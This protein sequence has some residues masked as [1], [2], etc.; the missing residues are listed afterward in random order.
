MT[1]YSLSYGYL[2]TDDI[3]VTVN[4]TS[5]SFSFLTGAMVRL[6][7]APT[8]TVVITRHTDIDAAKVVFKDGSTQTAKQRNTQTTQ[9][10]YAVQEAVDKSENSLIG[11]GVEVDAKGQRLKNL[12][13]PID[14][15][16]AVTRAAMEAYSSD[17]VAAGTAAQLSA[18]DSQVSASASQDSA[19]ASEVFKDETQILRDDAV[20]AQHVP[21]STFA[22]ELDILT[23]AGD[24][25][26]KLDVPATG[27]IPADQSV[28]IALMQTVAKNRVQTLVTTNISYAASTDRHL[29]TIDTSLTT[30]QANAKIR[31]FFQLCFDRQQ[32]GMFYIVRVNPDGSTVELGTADAAGTRHIG[33]A[34]IG[35]DNDVGSTLVQVSMEFSDLT[36]A[37]GIY[38]Y[39]LHVRGQ[40]MG[41]HFNRTSSGIDST[42]YERGSSVC[43][44]QELLV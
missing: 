28:A 30:L 9:L 20:A 25:R 38:K 8:G 42:D 3:T 4:G 27:D 18:T 34:A 26:A 16:D 23:T 5:V 1:D 35:F 22:T 32:N 44:L 29:S 17:A 13:D 10:L 2:E 12:S 19:D 43:I 14:P 40:S 24:M 21:H 7:D 11:D 36:L 41:F 15:Q 31:V 6:D 39:E 37:A 33:L